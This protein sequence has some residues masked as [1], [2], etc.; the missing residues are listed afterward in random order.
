MTPIWI[1]LLM[2]M[3]FFWVLYHW[4]H[5]DKFYG[6][7]NILNPEQGREGTSSIGKIRPFKKRVKSV[8][9]YFRAKFSC[10]DPQEAHGFPQCAKKTKTNWKTIFR[11]NFILVSISYH[12]GLEKW[13]YQ[14]EKPITIEQHWLSS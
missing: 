13:D 3:L 9:T 4:L 5:F 7:V 8:T 2:R 10:K 1:R 11:E 6:L 14:N 12:A